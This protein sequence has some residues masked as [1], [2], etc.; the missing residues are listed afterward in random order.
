MVP[1]LKNKN[2]VF[3]LVCNLKDPCGVRK[4]QAK[5]LPRR[6]HIY[7]SICPMEVS[8]KRPREEVDDSAPKQP[9]LKQ[10]E[11]SSHPDGAA[12]EVSTTTTNNVNPFD[13]ANAPHLVSLQTTPALSQTHVR[14]IMKK[15]LPGSV[16]S[17]A[18][19]LVSKAT[20][21]LL[22]QLV[23]S[24]I[25]MVSKREGV[26]ATAAAGETTKDQAKA[27]PA[28][29]RAKLVYDDLQEAFEMLKPKSADGVTPDLEFLS[30]VLPKR[31]KDVEVK[32]P[33][34]KEKEDNTA[35]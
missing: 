30:R 26:D 34:S 15:N 21:C 27:P 4:Q 33:V 12:S 16:S 18:V 29:K 19:Y 20:E 23:H 1:F 24:S 31:Q 35:E 5:I 7:P 13:V 3:E 11:Q 6:L 25:E 14:N 8:K 9:A 2:H 22:T 32:V 28:A 10:E 17:N